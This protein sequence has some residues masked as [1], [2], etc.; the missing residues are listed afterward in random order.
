MNNIQHAYIERYSW[1]PI[2]VC[3]HYLGYGLYGNES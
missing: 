2:I 3:G 1:S